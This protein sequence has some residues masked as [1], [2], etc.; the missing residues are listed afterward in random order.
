MRV[1]YGIIIIIFSLFIGFFFAGIFGALAFGLLNMLA[2]SIFRK[3][4]KKLKPLKFS[5]GVLLFSMVGYLLMMGFGLLHANEIVHKKLRGINTELVNMGYR[6][7]WFIIS[8]KRYSFYNNLLINSVKND[9]SKHLKGK[10]IDI[11][12]IDINSDGKYDMKDF[13]LLKNASDKFATKHKETK[14]NLYHYFG[15]GYFSQHMVH[16]EL[17]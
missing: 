11:Y 6:P 1:I 10:A 8:Q 7:R 12:V 5:L 15:K 9:R 3:E 2:I 16:I 17:D 13:E 4:L 14:G